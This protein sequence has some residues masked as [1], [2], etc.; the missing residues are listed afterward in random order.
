MAQRVW[1]YIGRGIIINTVT[2]KERDKTTRKNQADDQMW[3]R[4]LYV[5]MFIAA[6]CFNLCHAQSGS[7]TVAY[8]NEVETEVQEIAKQAVINFDNSCGT[9]MVF[10]T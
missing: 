5:T 4:T 1:Y 2:K 10:V 9:M 8:I 7:D 3:R 6:S